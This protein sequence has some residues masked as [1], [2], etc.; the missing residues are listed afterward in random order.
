ML[1]LASQSTKLEK[2]IKRKSSNIE[3]IFEEYMGNIS[4]YEIKPKNKNIQIVSTIDEFIQMGKLRSQAL[5][6]L[7]GFN[8]EFPEEIPGIQYDIYD[9]NSINLIYK[10]NND[11]AGTLRIIL[12]EKNGLQS[13]KYFPQFGKEVSEFS[14]LAGSQNHR[15]KHISIKLINESFKISKVIG[16]EK[17]VAVAEANLFE[18][19]LTKIGFKKVKT[20]EKYGKILLPTIYGVKIL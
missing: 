9:E 17:I 5:S 20:F 11:V 7:H 13:Q 19:A 15:N 1:Q 4:K 12:N 18:N 6:K 10:V 14:R 2:V 3:N 8:D 16:L